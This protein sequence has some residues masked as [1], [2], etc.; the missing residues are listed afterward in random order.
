M[1]LEP[2]EIAA[3]ADAA[4]QA[5]PPG[6]ALHPRDLLLKA[7]AEVF[8]AMIDGATMA[9]APASV[10]RQAAAAYVRPDRPTWRRGPA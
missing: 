5:V 4:R 7:L 8:D 9:P 2:D 10:V 6:P 1:F 3:L